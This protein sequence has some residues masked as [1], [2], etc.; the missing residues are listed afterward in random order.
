MSYKTIRRISNFRTINITSTF[1][2][3]WDVEKYKD[4]HESEEHWL[5]RKA[6][7]ERW[8]NNYPEERLICL[9]RVFCNVELLGC[10]YPPL[11]MQEI[12]QLSYEVSKEYREQRKNKLKR[13]FVSASEAAGE[14]VKG[15]KR[16]GGVI[17]QVGQ[18]VPRIDFVKQGDKSLSDSDTSL[19][20]N[21]ISLADYDTSLPDNDTSLADYDTNLHASD[22]N[23]QTNDANLPTNDASDHDV[24]LRC[25]NENPVNNDTKYGDI[26]IME[27]FETNSTVA[28]IRAN[29]YLTEMENVK[30]LSVTQFHEGMFQTEFGKMVLLVRPW[31]RKFENLFASTQ[32]CGINVRNNYADNIFSMTLQGRVIAQSRGTKYEARG[33][34]ENLA[35]KRFREN[36]ISVLIKEQWIALG[37]TIGHKDV[38]VQRGR[39]MFGTPVENTVAIKMMKMMGWKGGGL[40]SD[41]QGIAEP[42][43]PNL[44]LVN[45]AGLGSDLTQ[46]IRTLRNSAR[47]LMQRYIASDAFDVDL[48]FS[49]EFSKDERAALH[50]CAQ[51]AGL[52]SKSYG[53]G[54]DRSVPILP[55]LRYIASDAFDVD[56]VFSSEF[57]K[58]ER[59][60]L[61]LCAQRAGLAS[62]SY[63]EGQDRSVPILPGLRY[64]ASDAFDVDLVFSSEFSKDE[65]AALHLC[66]QR[67]GLAS[68]SYGEGQDRSVPI[69]PGLRYIA[70]DAFDVDLVFSSEFSKDERA[71]LHLCA[72]RAG[73]ASKSYGEGQDR[74]VPILPG[75]RYIA[76]DAFDVDLVFSSE[77]SKDERAALHLCA[78]RAGLASKSYGEG[79]DRSVPILPGLRYIASDA[80]DV[81]LVF[82][83]EF[84]KDERAALHLCAQRAGLASKSYGEGQDRSV[85]ILPGLRDVRESYHLPGTQRAPG[86]I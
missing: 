84:S 11:V 62:K 53:E 48:V 61:H 81:D 38:D 31:A 15:I 54:Q 76:S 6:F 43:K 33:I 69:L 73:L 46:D 9:A 19:P 85:P 45:R 68:K 65:R 56:L 50:L 13:T 4:E 8:K 82:S 3:D 2:E 12:T 29:E 32:A 57:S 39:E 41:A 70:S 47:Q 55:G 44:Q 36:V 26:K 72:Q 18:K 30:C 27:T 28:L 7:M 16:K 58:D 34:V 1:D 83:S 60:A 51:R 40:G 17:A 14:K 5:L 77:F 59:A 21:D 86:G 37:E 66:A 64:I 49:S 78:Q 71:A 25:T 75:L 79:Q 35:W 52:A 24:D 63:G 74:S 22:T 80:F 42:I 10:R 23:L 20:D 67:A